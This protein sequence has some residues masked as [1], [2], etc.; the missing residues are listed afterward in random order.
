[1]CPLSHLPTQEAHQPQL[2]SCPQPA[3]RCPPRDMPTQLS[4][5]AAR[6]LLQ[7]PRGRV[8]VLRIAVVRGCGGGRNGDR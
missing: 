8:Y 6:S 1:M 3:T 2:L 4:L 7:V 5:M